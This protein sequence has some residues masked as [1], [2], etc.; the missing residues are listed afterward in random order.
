MHGHSLSHL[1]G[2]YPKSLFGQY[3]VPSTCR[4]DGQNAVEERFMYQ[5]G[6]AF[7]QKGCFPCCLDGQNAVEG[8]FMYQGGKEHDDTVP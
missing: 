4:L 3:S 2:S 5:G 1:R 6:K 8:R 7:W